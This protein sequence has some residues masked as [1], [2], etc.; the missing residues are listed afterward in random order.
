MLQARQNAQVKGQDTGCLVLINV[1]QN[2]PE[3][4]LSGRFCN[5]TPQRLYLSY[6]ISRAITL[7]QVWIFWTECF[8]IS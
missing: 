8:L 4:T 7:T 5:V 6:Y 1:S 2:D 3:G